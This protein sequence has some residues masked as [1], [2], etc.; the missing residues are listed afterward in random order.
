MRAGLDPEAGTGCADSLRMNGLR[1]NSA[2]VLVIVA[3]LVAGAGCGASHDR[4]GSD[5]GP[6]LHAEDAASLAYDG[7][8]ADAGGADAGVRT[9]CTADDARAAL[10]PEVLCDGLPRWYWNGDDCFMIDCGA[11]EGT[12][13]DRGTGSRD[14]CFAAHATCVPALCR[15]SGG[16]WLWWAEEC[17][18]Y[19]CGHA[20]PA[21]C[22]SGFPVCDCGTN[23]VFDPELGC[24]DMCGEVD[25][26]P[27]DVLCRSTGGTW[28]NI[29]CDAVCGQLCALACAGE[30]C[31]CGA[32]KIFDA[33]RGCIESAQCH[34][35]RSGE[36]CEG[37]AR[38]ETGTICCQR[39]GGA[40]CFGPPTC[41]APLCDTDPHTDECGNNDLAA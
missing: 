27:R 3:A 38:C 22:E 13:C 23:R 25:P 21:D 26:L 12:E 41:Q 9:A 36:T 7:G 1:L 34:D 30:A 31:D 20:P 40:G 37:A 39:C 33:E 24:V 2:H 16:S 10:C 28:G 17:G 6:T 32:G 4:D 5:A 35:R 29:C 19:A 14:A 15:T 11:C 8:G 18:H